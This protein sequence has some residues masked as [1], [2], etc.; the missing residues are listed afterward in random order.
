[1]HIIIICN[2]CERLQG[3]DVESIV[4]YWPFN[5]RVINDGRSLISMC[6]SYDN[7]II[8]LVLDVSVECFSHQQESVQKRLV[9]R[10]YFTDPIV[11]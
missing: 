6:I 3:H 4:L 7:K 10:L 9:R 5:W 1:M 11:S 8:E 2:N